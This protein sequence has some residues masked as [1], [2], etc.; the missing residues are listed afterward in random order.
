MPLCIQRQEGNS[1]CDSSSLTN[2]TEKL[3]CVSVNDGS[4]IDWHLGFHL[5]LDMLPDDIPMHIA[6]SVLFAGKAIRES[7]EFH[8][9]SF[10]GVVDSIRAIAASH[11]WQLEVVRAKLNGHLKAIKDY[12]LLAKGDFFQVKKE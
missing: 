4:L 10:E 8:K 11:I 9:R 2:M 1:E 6:E 12:F 7:S 5:S 3:A